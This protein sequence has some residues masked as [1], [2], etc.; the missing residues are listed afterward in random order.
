MELSIKL[1]IKDNQIFINDLTTYLEETNNNFL[2]N[3]FKKSD[4]SSLIIV[5]LNKLNEEKIITNT[6]GNDITVNQDGWLKIYYL[7]LP[8]KKWFLKQN[9]ESLKNYDVIYYIDGNEIYWNNPTSKEFGKII[10]IEEL[11]DVIQLKNIKTSISYIIKD[12]IS[13]YNLQKCYINLCQQIFESR[14]ITQCWNKNNID[15]ELIYKRDLVWM[16]INVIKYMVECNQ[17]YEAER[18]IETLNSCNGICN[19]TKTKNYEQ[20]CGCS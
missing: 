2:L 1:N 16:G 8:T 7:V 11:L 15:S 9:S 4:T 19:N 12:Q 6:I 17:L 14:G 10:N 13:I 20:G 3:K 5:S 18:I